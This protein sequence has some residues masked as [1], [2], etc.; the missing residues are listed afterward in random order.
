MF[1]ILQYTV[2]EIFKAE[3]DSAFSLFY[4]TVKTLFI[5]TKIFFDVIHFPLNIL[6][7]VFKTFNWM[8]F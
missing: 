7:I 6:N 4:T 5:N 3:F 2:F 1:L 8:Q